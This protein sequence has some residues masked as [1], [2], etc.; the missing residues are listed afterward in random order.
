[1]GSTIQDVYAATRPQKA[2]PAA[3][4]RHLVPAK[5]IKGRAR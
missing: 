5:S 3:K 4:K 1:L 2:R